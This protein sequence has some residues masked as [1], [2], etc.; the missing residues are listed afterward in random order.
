MSLNGGPPCVSRVL[1][2]KHHSQREYHDVIF[3]DSAK[4]GFQM[5]RLFLGSVALI[6]LGLG[7]PAAFAADRAV[8]AYTP[9]PPAPVYTWTGCYVGASAGYS[10]GRTDGTRSTA[11]SQSLGDG[12]GGTNIVIL[13]GQQGRGPYDM[14]GM[15]G[16]F[17][18][19][20]NYQ[21]GSWVIGFEG[22]GSATNK[23]GQGFPI[24][25]NEIAG[26][27]TGLLAIN[28][29]SVTELQERWLATARGRLGWTV[30]DKTMLYVTGGGAWAKVDF[31]RWVLG[32]QT[33]TGFQQS[34]WISGWT[35]GAGYEYALGYGWSVKGEYLYVDFGDYTTSTTCFAFGPG[36]PRGLQT[37]TQ[38]S[39]LRDHIFRA[40]MNYK[41]W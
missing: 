5:K 8:P 3:T 34:D 10:W 17:Q 9:P 1:L 20:C 32:A 35:V 15:I 18:G 22:D 4:G 39:H 13:G 21:V 23:S 40:G 25:A 38:V 36:C 7:T 31:S 11:A 30:W 12:P 2:L 14:N 16:G 29:N 37:N 26:T 28:P 19:G 6:A 41:F 27:A 24:L 33:T